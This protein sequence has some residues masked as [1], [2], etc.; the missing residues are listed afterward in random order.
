M[1][2]LISAIS[3]ILVFSSFLNAQKI[4]VIGGIGG[5]VN[6]N[7]ANGLYLNV[8]IDFQINAKNNIGIY[9]WQNL[10]DSD[11]YLP[12][13]LHPGFHLRDKSNLLPYENHFT[14]VKHMI[15]YP[16]YHLRSKP[17]RYN[18]FAAGFRYAYT[19]SW[20]NRLKLGLGVELSY[21]DLMF[22][23]Q[24]VE[25]KEITLKWPNIRIEEEKSI[26][27][28]SFD[29]FYDIGGAIDI[30]YR[31]FSF[32]R[33][34]LALQSKASWYPLSNNQ[35]YSMGISLTWRKKSD[36]STSTK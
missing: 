14:I 34:D 24:V 18:N 1:K 21:F 30:Q 22:I 25:L 17:N 9:V 8:G 15:T 4:G 11:K 10:L 16:G 32:G 26:P 2:N 12:K 29:T 27:I 6:N 31:L 28:F 20:A 23:N 3:L 19:P 13:P 35:I 7:Q 33:L 36:E 5:S